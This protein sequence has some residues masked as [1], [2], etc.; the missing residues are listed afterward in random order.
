MDLNRILDGLL[1][2]GVGDALDALDAR[3]VR[4]RRAARRVPPKEWPPVCPKGLCGTQGCVCTRDDALIQD[5]AVDA[6]I[7][8]CV[9]GGWTNFDEFGSMLAPQEPARPARTPRKHP[10]KHS[11]SPPSRPQSVVQAVAAALHREAR[12]NRSQKRLRCL[13]SVPR[14]HM[15]SH[16]AGMHGAVILHCDEALDDAM[17]ALLCYET[18]PQ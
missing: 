12:C 8:I 15:R 13:E 5:L 9:D 7:D 11:P 4:A 18:L 14:A 17:Y 1:S 16:H 6:D 2:E 10:R 3:S